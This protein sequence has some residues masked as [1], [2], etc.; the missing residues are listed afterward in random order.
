MR[1]LS[2]PQAAEVHYCAFP[3]TERTILTTK[4]DY[5]NLQLNCQV[6]P[7]RC[8]CPTI[9]SSTQK[10]LDSRCEVLGWGWFRS[11]SPPVRLTAGPP[12]NWSV[13]LLTVPPGRDRRHGWPG[14]P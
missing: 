9:G 10:V 4:R 14:Q 7:T 11:T 3:V 12:A 5:L 1:S 13:C 6:S 8:R 2:K